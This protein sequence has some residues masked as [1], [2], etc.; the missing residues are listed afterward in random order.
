MNR[1]AKGFTLIEVL[2]AVAIVGILTSIALPLYN[3]YVLRARLTEAF[4]ALG[5]VQPSAE[6]FW[7]N[8]R[9]FE[10]FSGVPA[11]TV[12][13]T[14]A[15]SDATASTYKVTATGIGKVTGFVY[16]INHS[17]A[18]ATTSVPNGWTTSTSCW[19]DRKGGLC[20]Q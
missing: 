16:T 9:T 1:G 17:G 13:F 20:T 18:R 8:N 10:H 6:Q 2:I 14:Y 4:A 7:L 12:N 19:V 5:G 3:Q 15:L 11:D